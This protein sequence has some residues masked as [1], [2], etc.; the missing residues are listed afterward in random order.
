MMEG[1]TRDEIGRKK[2]GDRVFWPGFPS[3]PP[4]H[5]DRYNASEPNYYRG[6][7]MRLQSR[8]R[9]YLDSYVCIYIYML[10]IRS[11]LELRGLPKKGKYESCDTISSLTM[12]NFNTLVGNR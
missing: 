11:S 7:Q 9:A 3:S 10:E 12:N 6:M 8:Y 4:P 2:R 5:A 1:T